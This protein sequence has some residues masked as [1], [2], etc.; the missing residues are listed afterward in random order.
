MH[1]SKSV[2]NFKTVRENYTINSGWSM[3]ARL[4][5]YVDYRTLFL[6]LTKG[7]ANCNQHPSWMES[8]T[9]DHKHVQTSTHGRLNHHLEVQHIVFW[10]YI[11]SPALSTFLSSWDCMA[12]KRSAPMSCCWCS[13]H[14]V[15]TGAQTQGLLYRWPWTIKCLVQQQTVL[16]NVSSPEKWITIKT[17][18]RLLFVL[19]PNGPWLN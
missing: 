4:C 3:H 2:L 11:R 19:R 8:F 17:N 16:A 14:D 13:D 1:E 9:A 5:Y 12:A 6:P 10:R 18:T 15:G 7:I